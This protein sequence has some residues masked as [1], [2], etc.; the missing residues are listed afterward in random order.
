MS[1][2]LTD[3]E[4]LET[5]RKTLLPATN[6]FF[7]KYLLEA[8]KTIRDEFPGDGNEHARIWARAVIKIAAERAER[9]KSLT[10]TV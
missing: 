4:L 2:T 8:E 7:S 6:N 3:D 9:N 5:F 10:L 1:E